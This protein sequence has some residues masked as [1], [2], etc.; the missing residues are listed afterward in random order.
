MKNLKGCLWPDPYSAELECTQP[1]VLCRDTAC[2]EHIVWCWQAAVFCS[3]GDLSGG[4]EEYGEKTPP[5]QDPTR[6]SMG[7][8]ALFM[9]ICSALKGP[10]GTS[11]VFLKAPAASCQPW[12]PL[13]RQAA[14][15]VS[16]K[17]ALTSSLMRSLKQRHLQALNPFQRGSGRLFANKNSSSNWAT[18]HWK[19]DHGK[20]KETK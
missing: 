17:P 16:I 10:A 14:A 5:P 12:E 4:S 1:G 9:H 15:A 8:S 7:S 3:K 11:L 6:R 19:E 20:S 18:K 2:T 13:S